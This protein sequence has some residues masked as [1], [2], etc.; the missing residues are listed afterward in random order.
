MEDFLQKPEAQDAPTSKSEAPWVKRIQYRSG[1]TPAGFAAAAEPEQVK[2]GFTYYDKDQ[3][4]NFALTG[5]TASIV[6]ILSGVSGTVPNGQR[7][8]NYWSSLVEDT[9][10]QKLAVFLGSGDNRVTV[11]SGIYNDFKAGLPDGVG[12][13]KY[14]VVYLHET[15]ECALIE[16]TA[17]FE[18]SIKEAI[19][20]QTGQN[21]ARINV[22]NLFELSTK[23]WAV[24]FQG[25]FSKRNRDGAQWAGNGDMFFYPSL[26]AG[27]VA[28][29]KFPMLP[30]ISA[31]V[32]AYVESG[33]KYFNGTQPAPPVT[34]SEQAD[35]VEYIEQPKKRLPDPVAVPWPTQ[36]PPQTNEDD[37]PF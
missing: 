24:R 37:L 13:M 15:K 36:A 7:Y 6:G 34:Q 30:E 26:V 17:S 2:A 20:A 8:D 23:F 12:Y 16:M 32:T 3:K 5:F 10:T 31:Q 14:A 25:S 28:T 33:Q 18:N 22:F 27:V 1:K 19:A 4:A 35:R 11:A 21:P 29:E 9:R